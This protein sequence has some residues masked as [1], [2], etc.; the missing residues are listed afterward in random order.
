ME[1]IDSLSNKGIIYGLMFGDRSLLPADQTYLLQ[2]TNLTHLMAI[3]GLHIGLAYLFGFLITR[4][5][6]YFYQ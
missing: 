5:V 6:Q 1:L 2:K 4:G 3:S